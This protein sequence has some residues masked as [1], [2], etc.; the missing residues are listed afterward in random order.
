MATVLL[1]EPLKSTYILLNY[2]NCFRDDS[3][4]KSRKWTADVQKGLVSLD[5]SLVRKLLL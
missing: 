4:K 2:R 3:P 5:S 1:K